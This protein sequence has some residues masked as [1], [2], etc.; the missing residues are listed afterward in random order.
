VETHLDK[1]ELHRWLVGHAVSEKVIRKERVKALLKLTPEKA[2]E[3][4]LSLSHSRFSGASQ[5]AKPS[6]VLVAMRRALARQ[7]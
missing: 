2:W 7:E 4:Y 5:T 1:S 6:H 3:M